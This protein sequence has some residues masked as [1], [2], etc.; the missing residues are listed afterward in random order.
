M[1]IAE[2]STLGARDNKKH[3]IKISLTALAGALA[4]LFYFGLIEF[5]AVAGIAL[6]VSLTHL[7]FTPD[8]ALSGAFRKIA[9]SLAS[10]GVVVLGF[11]IA[12]HLWPGFHHPVVVENFTGAG[13]V[14]ALH[15]KL[16]KA[17]IGFV[18]LVYVAN[19]TASQ[20]GLRTTVK[21]TAIISL[22]T[23][24]ILIPGA[25]LL[26]IKTWHPGIP[27]G[28]LGWIVSNLLVTCVAEEAYFRGFIQ[29]R[30]QHALQK[31]VANS[32]PLALV[33]CS[34]L[35][36]IAH[37]GNGI[38]FAILAGVAG[39][40]YGYAFQQTSRLTAAIGV[41]FMLNLSVL[42]TTH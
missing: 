15:F 5:K 16:D 27:S 14:T 42:L 39:L 22:V 30:L 19:S 35:F 26:G 36:A 20:V 34:L 12:A 24:A 29:T 3:L 6:F 38:A 11:V 17:I 1:T 13:E 21:Y 10:L 23:V 18:L 7:A 40:F 9:G 41:H 31:R 4:L 8:Q 33:A 28:L 2:T 37:L 25:I 32:A